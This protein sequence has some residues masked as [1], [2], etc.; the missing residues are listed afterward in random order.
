MIEGSN[1]YPDTGGMHRGS[2]FFGA[3]LPLRVLYAL[4]ASV[5]WWIMSEI[6]LSSRSVFESVFGTL[7]FSTGAVFSALVLIPYLPSFKGVFKYK[8]LALM[9][10]GVLSYWSALNLFRL[11][12]DLGL[13]EVAVFG[14]AG[15]VGAVIVG[16]GARLFIP[17]ALSQRGW[18]MLAAAGC[19]GGLAFPCL[20][21]LEVTAPGSRHM[22]ELL[23]GTVVWQ[24]L[25]CLA[26]YYGSDWRAREVSATA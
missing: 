26:L 21:P 14:E 3:P 6:D 7:S 1:N 2:R 8:A 22:L 20:L 12:D 25:V 10:C 11:A 24:L 4:I 17:L 5:L 19:L 13:G 9:L 18:L 16:I 15:L 23:P